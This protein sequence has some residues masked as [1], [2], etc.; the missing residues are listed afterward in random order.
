M[1]DNAPR[2]SDIPPGAFSV[3]R[4]LLR[5]AGLLLALTGAGT[6][7]F[8]ATEAPA[9]RATTWMCWYPGGTSL[10]CR[11]GADDASD[12]TTAATHSGAEDAAAAVPQ[13]RRPLPQIVH[14]ILRQPAALA[15]RRIDIPMFT[16]ALDMEFA[17]QLAEA[18]MCGIKRHCVVRFFDSGME[19]ALLVD[20]LEDP[21]LN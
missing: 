18:V 2:S 6:S 7:A 1:A 16:E 10:S 4:W 5:S 12:R 21:A 15:G 17:H 9:P 11:L 13:G 19:L 8:A 3:R 20:E 14:T